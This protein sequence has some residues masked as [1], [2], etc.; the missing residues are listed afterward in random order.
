M[1]DGKQY[2]KTG[3]MGRFIDDKFL[4]ITG[5]IKEQFKLTNGKYVV[6]SLLEDYI[7][8]SRYVAQTMLYGDNRNWIVALVVPDIVE[9]KAWA[10][11]KKIKVY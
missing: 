5:R 1:M 2:F 3:D 11:S 4:K 10:E 7:C 6:P 9:I 8:R